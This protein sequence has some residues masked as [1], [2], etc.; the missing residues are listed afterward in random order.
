MFQKYSELC[1]AGPTA[2]GGGGE[3]KTQSVTTNMLSK[4][5]FDKQHLIM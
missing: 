1:L 2:S 3:A 4:E 5:V